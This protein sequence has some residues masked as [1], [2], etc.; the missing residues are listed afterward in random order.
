AS[1]LQQI[2]GP[3]TIA[4]DAEEPGIETLALLIARERA[5]EPHERLLHDVV[6]VRCVAQHAVREAQ[7]AREVARDD[8]L[9]RLDIAQLRATDE[10]R[11]DDWPCRF[12][13][14]HRESGQNV[15][16]AVTEKLNRGAG[17]VVTGNRVNSGNR[18]KSVD[19]YDCSTRAGSDSRFPS[20]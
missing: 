1:L 14:W 3:A 20:P 5:V 9:E 11:I 18:V 13:I 6:R 19:A 10:R 15:C 12:R 2:G 17:G 8:G 7:A 4:E 16:H